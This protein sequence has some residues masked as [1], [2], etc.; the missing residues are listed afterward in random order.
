MSSVFITQWQKK[1]A[2]TAVNISTDTHT[3][4]LRS[5]R[6]SL[7]RLSSLT[8]ILI[9]RLLCNIFTPFSYGLIVKPAVKMWT[10]SSK[11]FKSKTETINNCGFGLILYMQVRKDGEVISFV[12]LC[13]CTFHGQTMNVRN[14]CSYLTPQGARISEEEVAQK[15]DAVREVQ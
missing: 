2:K 15:F 4:T 5:L 9:L 13:R 6:I 12:C 3:H 10:D 7:S 14:E 8:L 1:T 11:I